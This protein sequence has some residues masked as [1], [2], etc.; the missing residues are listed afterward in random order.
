M[1]GSLM[2]NRMQKR[3]WNSSEFDQKAEDRKIII[4][5]AVL[6]AFFI[7]IFVLLKILKN[8]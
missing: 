6:A 3:S 4:F 5:F 7:I 1:G 8:Q 2:S